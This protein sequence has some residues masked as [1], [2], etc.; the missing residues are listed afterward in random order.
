LGVENSPDLFIGQIQT[1]KMENEPR[2]KRI[3]ARQEHIP[4]LGYATDPVSVF[5]IQQVAFAGLEIVGYG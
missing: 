4:I 3:P 5:K 1:A 2:F